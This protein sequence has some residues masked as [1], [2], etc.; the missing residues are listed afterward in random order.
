MSKHLVIFCTVATME[1]AEKI[2]D[3][4][5]GEELAACVNVINGIKSIYKWKGDICRD[6]ELLL[7]IKSK[8][9]NF[10]NIKEAILSLHPYDVPE[11]I[12]LEIKDGHSDYLKWIDEV[13]SVRS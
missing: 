6:D 13:V 2:S 8:E 5:V 9:A 4:L 11:I 1:D 3:K 7:V 10:I 12:S